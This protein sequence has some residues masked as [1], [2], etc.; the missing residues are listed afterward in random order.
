MKAKATGTFI[1]LF[2]I[3]LLSSAFIF[4]QVDSGWGFIF[5]GGSL[6]N[7]KRICKILFEQSYGGVFSHVGPGKSGKPVIVLLDGKFLPTY[8]V[9]RHVS[10][11][12]KGDSLWK[13]VNSLDYYVI[14]HNEPNK[15]MV[16]KS[17]DS[18]PCKK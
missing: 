6:R 15:V 10:T 8:G 7:N 16:L 12:E 4:Y 17:L 5:P 18:L 11:L 2:A 3:G 13:P 14:K 9:L 1:F